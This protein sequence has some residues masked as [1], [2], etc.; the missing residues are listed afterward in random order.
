[1]TADRSPLFRQE[2]VRRTANSPAA[3]RRN[4]IAPAHKSGELTKWTESRRGRHSPTQFASKSHR[5]MSVIAAAFPWF[6]ITH[7]G[8]TAQGLLPLDLMRKAVM[9]EFV[10]ASSKSSCRPYLLP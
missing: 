5:T 2:V 4:S 6:L 1:V 7:V 8:N 10:R 9:G 3:K